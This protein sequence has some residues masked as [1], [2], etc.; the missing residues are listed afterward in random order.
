VSVNDLWVYNHTYFVWMAGDPTKIGSNE[1]FST[2]PNEF[3]YA[4]YPGSLSFA[5]SFIDNQGFIYILAYEYFQE[6]R[7]SN[8]IWKIAYTYECFGKS[9]CKNQ[10][11][12]EI[13]SGNGKCVDKDL[14]SCNDGYT[15]N[16]CQFPICFGKSSTDAQVCS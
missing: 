13:C 4:N 3:N 10:T 9:I 8:T 16:E 5:S 11:F 12:D 6:N 15:G 7:A 1:V 14:C 2:G